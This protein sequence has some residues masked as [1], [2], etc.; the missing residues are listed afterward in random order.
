[1][2]FILTVPRGGPQRD[3]RMR[4][5][6]LLQPLRCANVRKIGISRHGL[7]INGAHRDYFLMNS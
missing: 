3:A 1:M 2:V 4:K 7:G 6:T 5:H